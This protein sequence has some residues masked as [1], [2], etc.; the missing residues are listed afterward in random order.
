MRVN[1]E[2]CCP[3]LTL[4][5]LGFDII[6]AVFLIY[7]LIVSKE[8]AVDLGVSRLVGTS[9]DNLE[10]PAV[11]DRIKQSRNAVIGLAFL[12]VGFFLQM[13]GQWPS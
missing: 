4:L 6:G 12:V 11:K 1:G 5:G 8:K 3:W 10:L 9:L 7:G 2:R 13:L